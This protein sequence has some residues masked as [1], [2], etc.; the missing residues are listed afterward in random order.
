MAKAPE[1]QGRF[2][3][4]FVVS[5]LLV[6]VGFFFAPTW[7]SELLFCAPAPHL[8]CDVLDTAGTPCVAA[9][10]TTR[11]VY[12]AYAGPLYRL[13]RDDGA[14]L[15]VGVCARGGL[16]CVTPH[17]NF[18]GVATCNISQIYDQSPRGNHLAVGPAGG[19]APADKGVNATRL[20]LSVYSPRPAW[21][22]HWLWP[23]RKSHRVYGAYF[24][25]GES[26]VPSC[27]PC[28]S[29]T[30]SMQ[31][32][33]TLLSGQGYRRD[34]TD[35]MARGGNASETTFMVTSGKHFNDGCCFDFGNAETDNND[36]RA[37]AMQAI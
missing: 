31:L 25:K 14:E 1:L 17:E 3:W 6:C 30:C 4:P 20:L 35:G 27:L 11:A 19:E 26:H 15:D 18:C 5:V 21:G 22:S 24:E 29:H 8:P 37:G 34:Q 12:S 16:A 23:H 28:F 10:S 2:L 33:V 32:T 7:R 13:L 36:D 9:F